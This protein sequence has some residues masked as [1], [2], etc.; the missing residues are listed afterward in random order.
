MKSLAWKATFVLDVTWGFW[1]GMSLPKEK[2]TLGD[3]VLWLSLGIPFQAELQCLAL[4]TRSSAFLLLP[5]ITTSFLG[6]R[7]TPPL[8]LP[9][10]QLWCAVAF[11]RQLMVH[12]C[13]RMCGYDVP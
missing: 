3:A 1:E 6:F 13:G 12:F 7:E 2:K 4:L 9:C 10:S 8:D 5:Y 11:L